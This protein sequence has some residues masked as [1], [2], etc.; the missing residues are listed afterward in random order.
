[1]DNAAFLL[2]LTVGSAL[3][4]AGV[5]VSPLSS[6]LGMPVL[7]FFLG[8]G[9]LAGEDGLGNIVFDDINTAFVVS[10]IALAVILLDGGMRTRTSSF[11]VALRPSAVLATVGVVITAVFVGLATTWIMDLPLAA[12]MLIGAI[13]SSTD[14]AAVFSL[15]QGKGLSLN[16][17]V[18]ATLEIESGSNDPMAIFL[19]LMFINML[20][21]PEASVWAGLVMLIQQMGIGTFAGVAGGYVFA[22]LL[23]RVRLESTMAPILVASAGLTLFG[24]TSLI[25]GSGFL[26][27]Y[28][29]GIVLAT[30][31]TPLWEDILHIHDGLAWLAQIILFVLLG[32]LVTPSQL[33]DTLPQALAISAVLILIARPLSTVI[34][35]APFGFSKREH[36]Y[37]AWVGLRGAVPVVLAVFPLMAGVEGAQTIFQITFVIV[38]VSLILQG[39]T[40]APMARWLKLEVPPKPE[41]TLR[42]PLR[43]DA[44]GEFEL[45]LFPLKGKRWQNP[46]PIVDVHLPDPS[47]IV[48]FFS[49]GTFYERRGGLNVQEGDVVAV[50]AQAK[51]ASDVGRVLGWDEPP[52]RLSDRRF[53]GDFTMNGSARLR[54]V[55]ML[56]GVNLPEK[57]D[58]EMTLA[59]C[60]AR[61]SRG[62]PVVGDRLD[63]GTLLLVAREVQGDQV[64]KAGLK[65]SKQ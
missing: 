49:K 39:G 57:L 42:V 38:L 56:Y 54:D 17:R 13:V 23:K 27:I 55:Q 35:L 18:K 4:A 3:V 40:L 15:L 6:R 37:M 31:R 25:G 61:S 51:A 33:L 53:F 45:L 36:V 47:R 5:L 60:F 9:M 8:I 65:L 7:L 11:R 29:M 24:V 34:G 64:V 28:L 48:G 19:T 63:L 2:A 26:A 62:H 46:R 44:A 41:P 22:A 52:E 58:P 30:K 10:N 43:T 32:L 12:G 16:E 59:D 20:Q 21:D 1:M 50:F 14:A